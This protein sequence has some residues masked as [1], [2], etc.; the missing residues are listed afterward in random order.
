V[1]FGING[2]Q[3]GDMG[4]RALRC[5]GF[6]TAAL[7]AVASSAGAQQ[8]M[9]VLPDVLAPVPTQPVAPSDQSKLAT[10]APAEFKA[11]EISPNTSMPKFDATEEGGN[12]G[13]VHLAIESSQYIDPRYIGNSQHPDDPGCWE[14][15]HT[16]YADQFHRLVQ[17]YKN[18]Y[19]TENMLYLGVAVAIAAPL[20]NTHADQGI[21]DWYQRGAGNGQSH[22]A[23]QT[24][25]VFNQIGS[26]QYA[27]PVLLACSLTGFC[28]DDTP[29]LAAVGDFG[30]RS[31]RAL[32]VGAPTVGILQYGLGSDRPDAP[33][34]SQWR[35]FQSD[36]GVSGNAFVGA[37]PFLTAASM[38]DNIALKTL[39]VV[40]SI[41]PAWSR[42]HSD[43]HYFSQAFLGWSIAYLSVR[44][45][46]QTEADGRFHIVPC[47]IPK[48]VGL[49]VQVQ[50]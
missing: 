47:D 32:A 46:N 7:I 16:I 20:A 19:L 18:F 41:G 37:V 3:E 23:D 22:F 26:Y 29:A 15:L 25:N 13:N 28:W 10:D 17:D 45:V 36:H 30:N 2:K 44:S 6:A 43:D 42:I 12:I 48:G 24:A 50:Y 4:R 8:G 35:P 31:L 27:V 14:H 40:G 33:D 49:G 39:F 9:R 38:T 21:R 11:P 5:L 34:S 1:A